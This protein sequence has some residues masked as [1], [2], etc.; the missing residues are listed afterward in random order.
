MSLL[1]CHR[2]TSTDPTS[3]YSTDAQGSS[4]SPPSAKVLSSGESCGLVG[5]QHPSWVVAAGPT[6]PP[7]RPVAS[8]GVDRDDADGGASTTPPSAQPQKATARTVAFQNSR[9]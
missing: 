4:E 9:G 5:S 6:G 8:V 1:F 7:S 3:A 2:P